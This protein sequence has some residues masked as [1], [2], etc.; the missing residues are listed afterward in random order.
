MNPDIILKSFLNSEH[1][2]ELI[3]LITKS[4]KKSVLVATF[5]GSL[6]TIS[7][8][9]DYVPFYM[10]ST[11]LLAQLLLTIFRVKFANDLEACV[12]RK[13]E[14]QQKY[15]LLTVAL[16]AISGFLWGLT[17][18]FAIIYAP[19]SSV[20]YVVVMLLALIAG[21]TTTLGAVYHAYIAF[22]WTMLLILSSAL[23]YNGLGE[24]IVIA[25]I[26]LVAMMFLTRTGADYVQ[27]L[28]KI[29]ELSEQLKEFNQALE[30]RVAQEHAKNIEKDVQLMHQSRLAQMGEMVSMIAHQWRQPL[31]M[32]STAAT[33]ME[34]KVQLGTINDEICLKNVETINR[35]TQHLSSTIDDF[36]T[37]F[38]VG[39]EK[40]LTTLDDVVNVTLR[41]VK[42]YVENKKIKIN[43]HLECSETLM[44]YPNELKQVLLNLMKNA[45]DQLLLKNIK[46]AQINIS[47][48]VKENGFYMDVCD[49]A[50]GIEE[51][52]FDKI[53]TAYFTTK[54]ESKGTGLGLYMSQ[55]IVQE[56]CGGNI[57]AFNRGEGACFS[58]F[59][60]R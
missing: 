27:K 28:R 24:H 39:K 58:L 46:N 52:L 15:L 36:R 47:T 16:T 23:I 20:H 45:E 51:N 1:P 33:D 10:I 19:E 56:H 5:V 29:V 57:N 50:G 60:P 6:I 41:I 48:Y 11:W 55:K 35:L 2:K 53:F 13:G 30:V 17:A 7:L 34:F 21:A 32:I 22:I 8:L 18:W 59:I 9:C 40:E 37:F 31:H 14:D 25:F 54:E 12:E 4:I 43:T 38:V 3:Y 44:S 26:L 49:N 42:E